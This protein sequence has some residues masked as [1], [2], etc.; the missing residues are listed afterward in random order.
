MR[1][2]LFV[3]LLFCSSLQL[4]PQNKMTLDNAITDFVMELTSRLTSPQFSSNKSIA[5]ISFETNRQALMDYF[6]R[7]MVEKL[8]EE[9]GG[10]D[11]YERLR[12]ENLLKELDLSLTRY[13]SNERAQEIGNFIGADVV[14]YGSFDSIPMGNSGTEYQMTITGAVTETGQI[15]THRNYNLQ[16][17]SRLEGLL[18]ISRNEARLWT[19]GASVGS[20]FSRPLLMGT[21]HGTIAFVRYSFL[22]LGVDLGIFSRLQDES[23]FSVYPFAHYAF[24]LPFD[25]V[26]LYAG[27]GISY[28]WGYTAYQDGSDPDTSRIIAADG[29]IGANIMDF[30]DV[31]YTIRTN[32]RSVTNKFSVGFT[33]RFK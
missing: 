9:D 10:L 4:F 26:A 20:S 12:I 27:A 24:F 1:K 22:E 16:L 18:G 3:V 23:Y 33:Y 28:I 7:N 8:M 29:I 30:I 25:K 19:L 15:V 21:I 31:S 17:N 11:V 14:I 13:V 32:F 5:V 6:F 2:L